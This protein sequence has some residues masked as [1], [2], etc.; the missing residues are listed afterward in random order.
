MFGDI[1]D[2]PDGEKHSATRIR[3]AEAKDATTQDRTTSA[4]NSYL[5]QNVSGA[6]IKQCRDEEISMDILD[7]ITYI[8]KAVIY[9]ILLLSS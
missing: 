1:F 2:C 5:V 9:K 3:Y 7:Q 8:I 4:I 6:E